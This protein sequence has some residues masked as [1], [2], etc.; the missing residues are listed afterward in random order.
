ML[1]L[2]KFIE[3]NCPKFNKGCQITQADCGITKG[4]RC[5]CFEEVLPH[6]HYA[7]RPA[8][9]NYDRIETEYLPLAKTR[10]WFLTRTQYDHWRQHGW[11]SLFSSKVVI[12]AKIDGGAVV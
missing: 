1:E 10:T 2:M 9:F 3:D 8:G 7:Y 12:P 6:P 4:R 5:L 11:G